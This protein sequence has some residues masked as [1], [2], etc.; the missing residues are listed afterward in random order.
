MPVEGV[1][2]ESFNF[3]SAAVGYYV[4]LAA[5]AASKHMVIVG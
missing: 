1:S 5:V 2:A 3:R 4:P